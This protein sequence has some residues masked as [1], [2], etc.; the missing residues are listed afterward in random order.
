M[1]WDT[2]ENLGIIAFGTGAAGLVLRYGLAEFSAVIEQAI[3]RF[4]EE[5]TARYEADLEHDRVVFS[6]LHEE[7]ADVIIELYGRFVRFERD[8]RALT[9]NWSGNPTAEELLEDA[10]ASANDF[11]RYYVENKIYFPP[12]TCDAVERLQDELNDVFVGV[13]AAPSGSGPHGQPADV[14]SWLATWDAVTE[15]EVPELKRELETH[16]RDLLG[17]DAD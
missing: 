13:R 11:S 8:M 2:L 9:T 14:Q 17:V 6:R 10:R 15:D 5:K 7:R 12:D 1:V 4:F 3:D 16:F